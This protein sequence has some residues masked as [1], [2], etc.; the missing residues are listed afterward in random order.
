MLVF[1]RVII[2]P[3]W[4]EC[5]IKF[6]PASWQA[7]PSSTNPFTLSKVHIANHHTSLKQ[8]SLTNLWWLVQIMCFFLQLSGF[9][10]STLGAKELSTNTCD[11]GL[12]STLQKLPPWNLSDAQPT[13]V[14]WSFFDEKSNERKDLGDFF[15]GSSNKRGIIFLPTFQPLHSSQRKISGRAVCSLGPKVFQAKIHPESRSG[16]GWQGMTF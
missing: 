4:R 5:G 7:Y 14:P 8:I 12:T 3:I 10:V 13:W 15:S 9:M 16:W 11:V 6:S 1:R 2:Y